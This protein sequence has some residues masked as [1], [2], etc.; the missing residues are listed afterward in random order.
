MENKQIIIIIIMVLFL[1]PSIISGI[2][3]GNSF[4]NNPKYTSNFYGKGFRYNIQGWIYIHI[5]GEPYE[6]G[7]QYGYLASDEI[8][9][10]IYRWSNFA[11]GIDFMNI[12][13]KANLKTMIN[14]L[15]NGGIFAEKNQ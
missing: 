1:A 2:V 15:K 7:Y 3:K 14:Y 13:K 12:F 6:R 8:I 11:H 5:E 9:N 4:T 10:M